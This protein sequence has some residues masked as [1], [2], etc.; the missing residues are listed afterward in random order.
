MP[1]K[2]RVQLQSAGLGFALVLLLCWPWWTRAQESLTT[3]GAIYA[4]ALDL[5]RQH[6]Y[7]RAITE[8]KRLTVLF[9]QD[10]RVPTAHL[11]IGLALQEDTMLEEAAL[12]WQRWPIRDDPTDAT[13][14]AALKL[15]ELRFLQGQYPQA[16]ERLQ[17]FLERY[18]EGPLV[19]RAR[20]LLGLTWVLDG[21]PVQARQV[22]ARLPTDEPLYQQAMALQEEVRLMPPLPVQSPQVAGVLS[23]ILPG[24]GHL[25]AGKPLQALTAFALNGVFL[26]GAAYA[27]HEKLPVAGG[28]LLFFETGWYLGGINSAVQATREANQQHQ[29]ALVQRLRR[30]YAPPVLTLQVLQDPRLGLH[31]LW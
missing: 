1:Q 13:R 3:A 25:Y 19:T 12:H 6:D 7:Y 30:T 31:L 15:G 11:L 14:V 21:Q 23:G 17:A 27:F 26:A 22:F 24:S 29:Q 2:C 9:P 10:A 8:L 5:L 28:I 18:P 20:Y 4:F 16:A